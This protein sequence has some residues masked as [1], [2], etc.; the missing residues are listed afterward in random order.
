MTSE[1]TNARKTAVKKVQA[2]KAEAE[3]APVS[4]EVKGLTFSIPTDPR[5][6]PLELLETDDEVVATRLVL[7][8]EQWAAFKATKPTIG[9]FSDLVDAMSEARGRDADAGN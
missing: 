5:E 3:N 7:G 2:A 1:N 4:F 9:D 6:L 8:D